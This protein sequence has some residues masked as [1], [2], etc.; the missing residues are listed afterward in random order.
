MESLKVGTKSFHKSIIVN[1]LSK[2]GK[3]QGI[4]PHNV[5]LN[6]LREDELSKQMSCNFDEDNGL[7]FVRI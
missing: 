2:S 1:T 6:R 3:S 4:Q 5:V 7:D